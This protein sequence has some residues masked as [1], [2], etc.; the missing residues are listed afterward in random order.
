M[1]TL[2]VRKFFR[3]LAALAALFAIAHGLLLGCVGSFATV[4][5]DTNIAHSPACQ[6][7]DS[8][9]RTFGTIAATAIASGVAASA[10]SALLQKDH[11]SDSLG[12]A[13]GG[14]VTGAISGGA[15]W[16]QTDAAGTYRDMCLQDRGA[17]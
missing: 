7:L 15:T 2:G 14:I 4:P 11:P 3:K 9:R 1:K 13:V 17:K 8:K 12:F 16:A 5:G 6:T 10:A